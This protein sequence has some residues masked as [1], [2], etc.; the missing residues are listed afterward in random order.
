MGP[1]SSQPRASPAEPQDPSS[2]AVRQTQTRHSRD[3]AEDKE[4]SPENPAGLTGGGLEVRP[5]PQRT[6]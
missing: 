4:V 6:R 3:H 2:L 1:R 5:W